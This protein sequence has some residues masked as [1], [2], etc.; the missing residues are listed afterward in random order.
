MASYLR[1]GIP[2]WGGTSQ[3][4][5]NKLQVA[6]NKIIRYLTHSPPMTN[7]HSKYNELR[8][9]NINTMF[10]YEAAKFMHS[11][12]NNYSPEVFENYFDAIEH[13]YNTRTRNT[14]Y[15]R[16]PQPRT[17]RGKKSIKYRGVEVWT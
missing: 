14:S 2:A 3:T 16:T 5:I 6:Q 10:F 4:Q 11:I 9:M 8:I 13:S 7:V 12:H 1:Y 17:E 15:Y